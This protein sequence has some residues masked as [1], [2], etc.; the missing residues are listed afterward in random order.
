M[1]IEEGGGTVL[2]IAVADIP[3]HPRSPGEEQVL[4]LPIQ[5]ECHQPDEGV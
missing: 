2:H 4:G 1:S 3:A 5:V